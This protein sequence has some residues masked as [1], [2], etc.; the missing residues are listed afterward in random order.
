M[1]IRTENEIAWMLDESSAI[2]AAAAELLPTLDGAAAATAA[3]E[4]H[5]ATP[6]ESM[7][8][9]DVTDSYQR[10]SELLSLL[11]E[12]AYASGDDQAIDAVQSLVDARLATEQVAIGEFIAVGRD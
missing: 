12:A 6:P 10:A 7:R 9:S 2:E 3:L 1:T 4:A 8:L 11:T 5:R